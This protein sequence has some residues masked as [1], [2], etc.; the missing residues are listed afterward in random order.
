MSDITFL[1]TAWNAKIIKIK[2]MDNKIN[3]LGDFKRIEPTYF[4]N[5]VLS[6]FKKKKSFIKSPKKTLTRDYTPFHDIQERRIIGIQSDIVFISKS[7]KL[8]KLCIHIYKNKTIKVFLY[9][10]K[11]SLIFND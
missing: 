4:E 11:F 5:K 2:I 9:I 8:K 10:Y 6:K 1:T 7:K 3:S